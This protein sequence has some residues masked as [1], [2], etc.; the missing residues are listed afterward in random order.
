MRSRQLGVHIILA[1]RVF[2][3]S[4]RWNCHPLQ[5]SR[6]TRKSNQAKQG[7]RPPTVEGSFS[8]RSLLSAYLGTRLALIGWFCPRETLGRHFC[9]TSFEGAREVADHFRVRRA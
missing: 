5:E 6:L 8:A 4:I 1:G 7:G 2:G 9:T 3:S